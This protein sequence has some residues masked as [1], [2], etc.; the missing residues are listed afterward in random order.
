MNLTI[1]RKLIG[2]YTVILV[3]LLFMAFFVTHKFSESN[4]R[5]LNIIDV[6]AKKVILSKELMIAVLDAERNEKDIIIEKDPDR[7]EYYKGPKYMTKI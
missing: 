5:L 6:S 3:V 2:G 7:K 1:K 4:Q